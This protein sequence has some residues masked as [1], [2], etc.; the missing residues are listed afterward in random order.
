M[1]SVRLVAEALQVVQVPVDGEVPPSRLANAATISALWEAAWQPDR[2]ADPPPSWLR[3]GQHEAWRRTV[4]A[5]N[6]WG[7]ALLAEAVGSGKSWIALA[8]A[9]RFGARPL[10]IGPAA[11]ANEDGL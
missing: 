11:L 10:V 6:G 5:I 3:P 4:A 2:C 7:G 1:R 8:V 9:Q